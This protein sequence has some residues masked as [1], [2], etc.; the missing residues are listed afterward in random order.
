[1]RA[2]GLVRDDIV[3]VF[4]F[5]WLETKAKQYKYNCNLKTDVGE[6]VTLATKKHIFQE[7]IY[8]ISHCNGVLHFPS[9]VTKQGWREIKKVFFSAI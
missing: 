6:R 1:M 7:D 2:E 5:Y 3:M 8:F 9:P 4:F